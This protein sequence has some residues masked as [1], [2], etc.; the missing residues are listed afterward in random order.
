MKKG[1]F[2]SVPKVIVANK[3]DLPESEHVISRSD[4]E[5]FAAQYSAALIW[6][7]ALTTWNMNAINIHALGPQY[8]SILAKTRNGLPP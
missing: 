2:H 4:A 3:C 8:Q 1:L 6:G 5:T 7:S